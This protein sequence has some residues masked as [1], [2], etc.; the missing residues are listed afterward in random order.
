MLN[1]QFTGST[2]DDSSIKPMWE[3][4]KRF[5]RETKSNSYD[6]FGRPTKELGLKNKHGTQVIR[7]KSTDYTPAPLV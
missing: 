5:N 2:N 6:R 3:V 4:A 1:H 7:R